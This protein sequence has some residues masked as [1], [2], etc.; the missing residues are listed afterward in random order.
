VQ[1]SG[2][3]GRHLKHK[4]RLLILSLVLVP[5]LGRSQERGYGYPIG[6]EVQTGVTV[7]E[8]IDKRH[9]E[10]FR[11]YDSRYPFSYHM[12]RFLYREKRK[13]DVMT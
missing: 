4:I 10:S 3:R 8:V 13:L 9:Q 5:A 1:P 11:Y 12:V 7:P 2:G 6:S